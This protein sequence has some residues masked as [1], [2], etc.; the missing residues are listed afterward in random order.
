MSTL[1]TPSPNEPLTEEKKIELQ[2]RLAELRKQ[3]LTSELS[4]ELIREGI[5]IVRTLRRTHT[6][7]AGGP[8]K[9]RGK[10]TPMPIDLNSLLD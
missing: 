1:P 4:L 9:T 6:G 10:K 8:K 5:Q 2:N 3:Q 7:P